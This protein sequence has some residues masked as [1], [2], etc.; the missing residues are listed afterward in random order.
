[1]SIEKNYCCEALEREVKDPVSN[2]VEIPKFR[3]FLIQ[4]RGQDS[5]QQMW[6]CPWCGVKLPESLRERRFD[7]LE[8][9]GF[10][11]AEDEI[12]PEFLT[13]EWWINREL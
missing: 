9:L 11:P 1:M 6:F 13:A 7:E 3:E 4:R 5:M 2:V 8:G 12:P 10:D